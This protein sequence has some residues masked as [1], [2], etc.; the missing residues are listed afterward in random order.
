MKMY[1]KMAEFDVEPPVLVRIVV[2][3]MMIKSIDNTNTLAMRMNAS[4]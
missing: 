4:F 1:I 3:W 2:D